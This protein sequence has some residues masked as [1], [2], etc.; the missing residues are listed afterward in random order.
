VKQD[1]L[2][3]HM[4][5]GGCPAVIG[6]M[7]LTLSSSPVISEAPTKRCVAISKG[8]YDGAKRDKLL[9]ARF[10]AYLKTGWFWRRSYW[11]CRY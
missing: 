10:G 4:L 9:H 2:N 3:I 7:L 6:L 5:S 1:K 8:E 11:Y